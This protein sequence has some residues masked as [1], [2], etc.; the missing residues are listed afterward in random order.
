MR[1]TSILLL[2]FLNY[3]IGYSQQ[4]EVIHFRNP[5]FE[6][7]AYAAWLPNHWENCGFENFSA[8]DLHSDNVYYVQTPP[9]DGDTYLGMV[10]R[11][12]NTWE[13]IGQ[14]LRRP[15][16]A[17]GWNIGANHEGDFIE[18]KDLACEALRRGELWILS[19]R[20]N[21]NS[22]VISSHGCKCN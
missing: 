6:G 10:T 4:N 22:Q 1:T 5:S 14:E 21:S 16:K 17:G 18:Y 12:N 8:P 19:D 3:D 15:V 7:T 11:D 20:L 2:F 13:R 9:L